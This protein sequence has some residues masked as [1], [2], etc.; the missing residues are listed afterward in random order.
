MGGHLPRAVLSSDV[1]VS[2]CVGSHS[3]DIRGRVGDRMPNQP[4]PY[5]VCL[6]SNVANVGFVLAMLFLDSQDKEMEKSWD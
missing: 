1:G 6:G 5:R 3:K 4:G 2:V